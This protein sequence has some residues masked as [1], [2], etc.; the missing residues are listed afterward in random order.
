MQWRAPLPD[1]MR[2][3]LDCLREDSADRDEDFA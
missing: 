1:D 2:A 3:L